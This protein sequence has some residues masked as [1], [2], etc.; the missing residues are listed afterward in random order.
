MKVSQGEKVIC[1]AGQTCH[2]ER[3]TEKRFYAIYIFMMDS[4]LFVLMMIV[5]EV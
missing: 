5:S 3:K 4:H 1:Y 2:S